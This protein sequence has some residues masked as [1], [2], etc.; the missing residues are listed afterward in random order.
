MIKGELSFTQKEYGNQK[1]TA[2]QR[3]KQDNFIT[4]QIDKAGDNAVRAEQQQPENIF[5]IRSFHITPL[6]AFFILI[7]YHKNN[8][9]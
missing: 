7:G 6:L 5:Q 9:A 3:A 8:N 4:A 2:D 1:Q